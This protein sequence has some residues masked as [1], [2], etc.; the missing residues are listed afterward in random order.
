M[1]PWSLGYAHSRFSTPLPTR[2]SRYAFLRASPKVQTGSRTTS[3]PHHRMYVWH[4]IILLANADQRPLLAAVLQHRL[5]LLLFLVRTDGAVLS[6]HRVRS[7]FAILAIVPFKRR[8]TQLPATLAWTFCL[9]HLVIED[10]IG[11]RWTTK[12]LYTRWNSPLPDHPRL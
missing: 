7:N 10:L 9:S 11:T 4:L 6:L 3:C 2:S 5:E 12:L 1:S 8:T